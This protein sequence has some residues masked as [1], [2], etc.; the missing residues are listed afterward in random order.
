[1]ILQLPNNLIG[2][3][4]IKAREIVTFLLDNGLHTIE[5]KEIDKI[6]LQDL[7]NEE[8]KNIKKAIFYTDKTYLDKIYL[9]F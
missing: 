8:N 4:Y 7:Y 1:M 2:R 5:E 3:D 6:A 9:E